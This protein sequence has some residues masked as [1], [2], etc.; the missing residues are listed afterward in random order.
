MGGVGRRKKKTR[1]RSWREEKEEEEGQRMRRKW[2]PV[3][4]MRRRRYSEIKWERTTTTRITLKPNFEVYNE[5]EKRIND[6]KT[7]DKTWAFGRKKERKVK[8]GKCGG[9]L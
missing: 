3:V 6:I 8:W 1:R 9:E 7:E 5:R 2:P 4:G